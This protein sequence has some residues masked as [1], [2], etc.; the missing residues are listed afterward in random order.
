MSAEPDTKPVVS[1][2]RTVVALL[3]VAAVF[4]ALGVGVRFR[5]GTSLGEQDVYRL[6]ASK[7]R[8]SGAPPWV[9]DDFVDNVL[10]SSGLDASGSL[11]DSNLSQKLFQALTADPWVESVER[12]EIRFP[13]GAEVRL[14]YR[15]PAALVEL[16]SRGLFPVDRNGVL[17]PTDYFIKVAPEKKE[18]YPRIR[19]IRSMPLG[20]V[21]TLWGDP[22]VHAAAQLAGR[23]G[24]L[25]YE[26]GL[27]SI[28]PTQ[29]STP[30]GVRILCRL[31]TA[32]E[33]EIFWG[34]FDAENPDN[35]ARI[36]R[37][38]NLLE[39]YRSLDLIPDNFKP[40]DLTKE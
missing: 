35:D 18:D 32:G 38:R 10:K 36:A 2:K 24:T 5:S 23:L 8:V 9:P 14:T 1:R 37:L 16:P 4:V 22:S 25:A 29:E 13:S 7:I 39:N 28:F 12:V 17:L 21:G 20:T 15:S 40:I 34:A 33:T 6:S 27:M 26:A 11:L 31:R 3:F 19:G 30:T